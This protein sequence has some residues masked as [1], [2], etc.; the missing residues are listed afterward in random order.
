MAEEPPLMSA[1]DKH[2]S[3]CWVMPTADSAETVMAAG[4]GDD[5]GAAGATMQ[6]GTLA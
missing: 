2:Q 5:G 4:S 1:G 3:A 6:G